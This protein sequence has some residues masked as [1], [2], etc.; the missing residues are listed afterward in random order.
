MEARPELQTLESSF[1]QMIDCIPALAWSCRADGMAEYF[2]RSWLE[3]TGFSAGQAAEWGWTRAFHPDDVSGVV[4]YWQSLVANPGPGE[5]EAR[6]RRFDGEYRWFL[7]RAKPLC[8]QDGRVIKWYGTNTDVEDRKRAED[9]LRASELNL[10]L[11]VD[12]IPA[13]VC[14]M[15]AT[16]ELEIV[17]QQTLTYF[18]KTRE[19]LTDWESIGVV[20][21]DDLREVTA[22]WRHATQTGE[23][24]DVEHRILRATG[25]FRW[26]HVRGLPLRDARERIIRWYILLI[27]IDDRKRA[28]DALRESERELRQ[29]VDSVPGM[30][31]TANSKGQHEYANRRAVDYT[32]TSVEDSR[33][34][35][36]INT[37]HPEEQEFVKTE[38]LRC[39]TLGV[40]MDLNHR[41]RR[42]DGVYRW[43]HVRVEPLL[44]SQ[45]RIVRWYGLLTDIDDQIRAEET[46]RKREQELRLLVE[47]IPAL[48]WSATPQGQ[49]DYVSQRVLDY[50]G[51]DLAGLQAVG[52][53]PLV[54]PDDA[55]FAGRAWRDQCEAGRNYEATFRLRRSTG[56]YRW[57][58]VHGEPLRGADGC[59]V[60]WYGLMLDIDD[61]K[62]L[63]EAL[64][65][66]RR[67]LS[68]AMQIATVAELSASIAH[69]INQPLAAVV[70]NGHACVAWLSA[71]PPNLERARLTA[72]RMIRDGNS[73]A[74]VVRRI[75]ALFQQTQPAMVSSSINEII[76]EVLKLIA[77]EARESGT[78]IQTDLAASLP[79]V[80][81]DR[82]QLQQTLINLAHNAIEAMTEVNN[83]PKM[84]SLASRRQGE[85]VLIQVRDTG[86]GIQDA[87]SIFEPFFTTKDKGMGMG[88]A[89]CRSIIEAHGGRLW[90]EPNQGPGAT[91]SF[92]LPARGDAAQ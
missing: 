74:E 53:D 17:N 75:R 4:G 21:D 41:W 10:R 65:S 63:E 85:N 26:F 22:R 23:P 11:V 90:A 8:D 77:D 32:L 55:A 54:H 46:L 42:F 86:H 83:W 13:L 1:Q 28:Q 58:Q 31:A 14:T 91:F 84:L 82:V 57:F 71:N 51:S 81:A 12:T 40:P 15:T 16:G 2:N 36:F 19:E 7:L 72:E 37:I 39:S 69:E 33:D 92:T 6:L 89:I 20:H 25:D 62:Q 9:A 88:L 59:I 49:L 24:Y 3:Y 34:L 78:S 38:W 87:D 45:G 43:F 35:G 70:A 64:Q 68:V 76:T 27:D 5:F 60:K 73:T 66:A 56:E 29:L 79:L 67:R 44:D 52:W 50:T 47:T 48:I 18:G 61:R 30:I 80:V